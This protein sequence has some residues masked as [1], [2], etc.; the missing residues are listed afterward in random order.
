LRIASSFAADDK[1]NGVARRAGFLRARPPPSV[2]AP[3]GTP[4][5]GKPRQARAGSP[6]PLSSHADAVSRRSNI[7]CETSNIDTVHKSW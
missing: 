5:R 7:E 4:A 1:G 2:V 6:L 3:P